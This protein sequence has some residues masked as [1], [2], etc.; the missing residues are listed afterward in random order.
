MLSSRSSETS[1]TFHN[2]I[3]TG[4]SKTPSSLLRAVPSRPASLRQQNATRS[5]LVSMRYRHFAQSV[6]RFVRASQRMTAVFQIVSKGVRAQHLFE[7]ATYSFMLFHQRH[8]LAHSFIQRIAVFFC[9]FALD[10]Q[11]KQQP[12]FLFQHFQHHVARWCRC[13]ICFCRRQHLCHVGGVDVRGSG[14]ARVE[15]DECQS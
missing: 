1:S 11:A 13:G 12:F 15:K 14:V 4:L 9:Y 8:D 10:K 7:G 5:Q 2:R 6:R 3:S